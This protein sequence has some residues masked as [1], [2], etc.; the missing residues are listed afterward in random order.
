[1]QIYFEKSTKNIT[2]QMFLLTVISINKI[3]STPEFYIF[4]L[5]WKPLHHTGVL[6]AKESSTLRTFMRNTN[7]KVT[8]PWNPGPMVVDQG[9]RPLIIPPRETCRLR[10]SA[11][12]VVHVEKLSRLVYEKYLNC[13]QFLHLVWYCHPILL[14]ILWIFSLL[15]KENVMMLG[16][17][18]YSKTNNLM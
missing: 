8:H 9:R 12:R 11:L 13:H 4:R 14:R 10:C 2:H 7:V 3:L 18:A 17:T 16:H 6:F 15:V 5:E 1:M